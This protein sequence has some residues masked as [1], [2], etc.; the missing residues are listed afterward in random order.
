VVDCAL[1]ASNMRTAEYLGD[2]LAR[3]ARTQHSG[4]DQT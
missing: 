1:N 3:I 4:F 2:R